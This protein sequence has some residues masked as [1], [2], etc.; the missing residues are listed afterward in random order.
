MSPTYK[1]IIDAY[2]KYYISLEKQFVETERYVEFDYV[3]NGRTYSM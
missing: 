3:N 1:E 2:W